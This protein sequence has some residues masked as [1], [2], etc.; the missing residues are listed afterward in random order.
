MFKKLFSLEINKQQV[1][2]GIGNPGNG[3]DAIFDVKKGRIVLRKTVMEDADNAKSV[4]RHESIHVIVT[5]IEEDLAEKL[6]TAMNRSDAALT[7]YYAEH[8]EVL[9]PSR[10]KPR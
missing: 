5:Q 9:C 10:Q 1:P 4:L 7:T 3:N 8:P 2:V 6:E